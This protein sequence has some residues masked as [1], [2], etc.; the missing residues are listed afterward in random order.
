MIRFNGANIDV[1]QT[2]GVFQ[3]FP[4]QNEKIALGEMQIAQLGVTASVP[5]SSAGRSNSTEIAL[6]PA[7]GAMKNFKVSS[8]ALIDKSI[9]DDAGKAANSAIDAADPL[10]RKKRE[11]EELK[12]ENQINDEK[13]KL[14]NSNTNTDN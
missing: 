1:E 11:L 13:K 10:N 3:P 6:D 7:T 14:T 5:A 8:T 9:L 12:T 4:N 2:A